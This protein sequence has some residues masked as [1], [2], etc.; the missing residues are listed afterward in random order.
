MTPFSGEPLHGRASHRR[1]G[2]NHRVQPPHARWH[3]LGLRLLAPV[4]RARGRAGAD[5]RPLRKGSPAH[6]GIFGSGASGEP[7]RRADPR[8]RRIALRPDLLRHVP[9]RA[10]ADRAAGQDAAELRVGGDRAR[11]LGSSLLAQQPHRSLHRLSGAGRGQLAAAAWGHGVFRRRYQPCHAGQPGLVPLQPYGV[12]GDLL[13]GLFRRCER[14]ARGN[15]RARL[16]RLRAGS[17][18]CRHLSGQRQVEQRLQPHGGPQP[19]GQVPFI[20]CP[21]Q[22]VHALRR[23]VRLCHQAPGGGRAGRRSDLRRDRGDRGQRGGD[24]RRYGRARAGPVHQRAP[25][26]TAR[27][28]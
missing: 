3:S 22:R 21:S 5:Q 1:R 11:R 24:G 28:R 16:R 26:T 19:G 2:C 7:L 4:E 8:R 20:R 13:H 10:E 17:R 6:R 15:E 12:V 9:Q 25:P 18:R 27:W 14:P 23:N